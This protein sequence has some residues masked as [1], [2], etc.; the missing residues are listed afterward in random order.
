VPAAAGAVGAGP[1]RRPAGPGRGGADL[2]ES[3]RR[4]PG[5]HLHLSPALPSGGH[6]L[7][8]GGGRARGGGGTP[9]ARPGPARVRPGRPGRPPGRHRRGGAARGLH[10]ALRQPPFRRDRHGA[11]EP[12]R[13]AALPRRRGHLPLPPGGGPALR[14]RQRP[15]RPSRRRRRGRRHRLCPRRL[16]H[17]PA[18]PAARL[19]QPRPARPERRG[20]GLAAG[21]ALLP[22][23]PAHRLRGAGR[24]AGP[25]PAAAR[26]A[27]GPG[28]RPALPA[29]GGP[30]PHL[31]VPA[32]RP[33]RRRGHLPPDRGAPRRG[34]GPP[35]PP[36]TSSSCWTAPGAWRA[37]RWWRRGGP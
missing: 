1:P 37:G 28:L 18:R 36:A 32:A 26:G 21:A 4:A 31:A 29:G 14:P 10:P 7:P 27:A 19:P 35:L 13:A 34:A 15:G 16:A 12:G 11:P 2:R 23:Q 24:R 22:L 17:Q 20:A 3:S 25:V 6:R 30:S 33:R 5:G 9:G 8:P